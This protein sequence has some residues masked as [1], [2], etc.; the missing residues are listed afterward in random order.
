MATLS[1][2]SSSSLLHGNASS[3]AG[4]TLRTPSLMPPRQRSNPSSLSVRRTPTFRAFSAP[5]PP[6]ALTQDDLKKLAADKAVDYVKSGMVL[7][8]GTGSTAAFVVAKLG[9]L[10][11]SGQLTDIVG[12]PTSKRTQ[13][14]AASLN[15]PLSTL[16]DHPK[17]D[18]A[19]DG[20][21]EVDPNLD[22]VKGRGGALLREKMV[23]AASDKFVVVVDDT[24][25]VSGLGGSG[26]AMPVE[27]VQFCWKYNLL[28]LQEMFR[29]L[30][31]DA[32]LRLDGGKPYVTDN[33]NYIVDLYFKTPIKDSRA[34]GKE[35]SALEGVVEHGLFL[36]MA[37][38][39]IIAGKEGVSVKSK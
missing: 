25:L 30:D 34:A 3:A 17:L 38:A 31:C 13:E 4:T 7:G 15:I 23:E 2:I 14:Q 16:D 22:L 18:L 36:D 12:V 33:S 20:A 28:R 27:V 5:S 19:I 37:T 26:L 21:D 6:P 1:F 9:E 11:S 29:E 39:V 35:I 32:K 24:K 10:I 8:L